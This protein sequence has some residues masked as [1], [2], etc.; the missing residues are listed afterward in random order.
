MDENDHPL[1]QDKIEN[2]VYILSST[3]RKRRQT[4][5][6]NL[7]AELK[8]ATD[9]SDFNLVKHLIHLYYLKILTCLNDSVEACREETINVVQVVVERFLCF[10]PDAVRKSGE[11]V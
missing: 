8:S 6:A 1:L 9:K 2:N 3:D 10:K 4:A 5:L 7:H 11:G